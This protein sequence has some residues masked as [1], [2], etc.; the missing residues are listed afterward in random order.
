[1][2]VHV[3][4][5]TRDRALPT[6]GLTSRATAVGMRRDRQFPVTC[7]VTRLMSHGA[8]TSSVTDLKDQRGLCPGW[9]MSGVQTGRGKGF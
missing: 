9:G 8:C 4:P 5:Q 6:S 2:H 3:P 7:P 1:M